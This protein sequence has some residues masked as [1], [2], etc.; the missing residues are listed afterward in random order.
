MEKYH[1]ISG[2][3][4]ELSNYVEE[5]DKDNFIKL[6]QQKLLQDLQNLRDELTHESASLAYQ[7]NFYF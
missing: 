3:L 5:S 7:K 6:K 2:L 4:S 1:K